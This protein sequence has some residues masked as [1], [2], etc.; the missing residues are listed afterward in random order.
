M[1]KK[2]PTCAFGNTNQTFTE[3]SANGKC[4]SFSNVEGHAVSRMTL[5]SVSDQTVIHGVQ[6]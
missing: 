2:G 5:R 4:V 6:L 1:L 3:I